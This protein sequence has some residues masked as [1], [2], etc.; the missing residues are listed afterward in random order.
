METSHAAN[1][2][3][4]A[5]LKLRLHTM[6]AASL[7]L[8]VCYLAA[9]LSGILVISIPESPWPL[10]LGCAVLVAVLLRS[11]RKIWPI[12]IPAGLA[13][14]VL[15]DL[16]AGVSIRSIACL[17]L[18]DIG[19]ILVAA[20][21]VSYFMHG[22]PRLDSL[23]A[24]AKY[25]FVTVI[26][27]PLVACLIGIEVLHGDRWI[28]FRIAFVSEGLAF[29]TVAPA[30]LGWVERFRT[31][32]LTARVYYLEAAVLITALISLSYVMFVALATNAS[33]ALLY[34]LVPFLLWSALRFGSAGAGTMA[35]I[36]ALMSL[37]GAVHG[38]GPFTETDPI[39]RVFSLQ[40]F[41]LFTAGPFM[42]LAVLVEERKRQGSV[43]RESEKRFRLMA[44]SAP[45]MIWMSGTDKQATYFNHLW[46]DFTGRSE[47]N[48]QAGL[49][50]VVHP[51]DHQKCSEIY[52]QAF[53]Q[54]QP[55]RKECRLRRHD[56][57]YRWMLDIGVPRFHEDGTFAGYIG[58]CVDV[59]DCKHAEEALVSVNR[60]LIEA[61][62]QECTRIARELHD[63]LGQRLAL[64]MIEMDQLSQDLT[65]PDECRARLAE[66]QKLASELATDMQSLSHRLHSS[67]LDLQGVAAAMRG[68]CKEFSKQQRVEI[69]FR[70]SDLPNPVPRDISLCLYRVLQEALRNSA[71]H[72]GMR[73]YEAHLWATQDEIHLTIKDFG[74]GFDMEMAAACQ[75]LGLVSMRERLTLVG[76]QLS[77]QSQPALGTTLHAWVPLDRAASSRHS[78]KSASIR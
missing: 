53:D 62:D 20:W 37:W 15:Y 66:L 60:R 22:L 76:G 73:H 58:S 38:R 16:Q 26:L 56:G 17:I 54:R 77:I 65:H 28:N 44:N 14:F 29:L 69:D 51:D 39:S 1:S 64:L 41:L 3:T 12:L 42:V 47:A 74:K 40:L 45:V 19:E 18:A 9:K 5:N 52:G 23:K 55:F 36:V 13:G 63:D 35:S 2:P 8:G 21:G 11:P 7:M 24:F 25:T 27:G 61:Q 59:T 71:K 10:W 32:R 78:V 67:R 30:I 4:I 68:L 70:S 50:G 72:S 6:I 43:L 75:G 48:L 33:P 57:Q 46:L 49:A 34:S 31:W